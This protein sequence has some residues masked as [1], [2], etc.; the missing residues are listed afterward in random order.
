MNICTVFDVV[1]C[2]ELNKVFE[3]CWWFG[4][5]NINY[6]IIVWTCTLV[7]LKDEPSR[8]FTYGKCSHPPNLYTL[9]RSDFDPFSDFV[10][11]HPVVGETNT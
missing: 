5:V 3:I 10:N 6:F 9:R 4:D 2:N 8:L 1:I 11:A 7:T